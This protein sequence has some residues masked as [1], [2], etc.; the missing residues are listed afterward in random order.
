VREEEREGARG[1]REEKGEREIGQRGESLVRVTDVSEEAEMRLLMETLQ[2]F[3][4]EHLL[5][6]NPH[7][8]QIKADPPRTLPA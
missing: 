1:E 3:F 4:F 2:H 5:H 8:I 6:L 7:G